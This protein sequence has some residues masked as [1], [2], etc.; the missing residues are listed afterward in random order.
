MKAVFLATLLSLAS[1]LPAR[2]PPAPSYGVKAGA[3]RP[4]GIKVEEIKPEF[5]PNHK[6]VR[7]TYGRYH[8]K[9]YNE[10]TMSMG[11]AMAGGMS[12]MGGKGMPGGMDMGGKG[13]SGG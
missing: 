8:L 4:N 13:M 5:S 2:D 7:V 6:R 11:G 10:T 9:P 12:S 3:T 1:A